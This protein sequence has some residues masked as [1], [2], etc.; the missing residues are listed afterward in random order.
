[1]LAGALGDRL[2]TDNVC[3]PES[4]AQLKRVKARFR[5]PKGAPLVLVVRDNLS[6]SIDLDGGR[7]CLVHHD[8]TWNPARMAQRYGRVVRICSGFQPVSPR[9]PLLPGAGA[10]GGPAPL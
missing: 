4:A 1:M 3:A 5:E 7:P 2:G 8:L 10:G 9:G 6:E